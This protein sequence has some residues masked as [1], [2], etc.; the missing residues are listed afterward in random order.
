MPKWQGLAKITEINDTN[1][2]VLLP[3]GKTKFYNIMRI[4]KFFAPSQNSNSDTDAPNSDLNYKSEPKITGPITRAMKKLMQQKE[5]TEMAINVL[6]D[7]TKQQ[8]SMCEWKKN[9]QTIC[10]FLTQLLEDVTFMEEKI[11]SSTN[12]QCAQ[13]ANCS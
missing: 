3:N 5:A 8:C 7:L 12:N 13:S 10:Y 2:R 4:K 6:C 1:A 11:G 9:V